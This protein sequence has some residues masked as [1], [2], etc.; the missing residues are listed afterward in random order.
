VP[1]AIDDKYAS[2]NGA[3]GFLGEPVTGELTA[4]DRIG[5]YRHYQ[6]GSIYWSP[7]TGA[8]ETHGLIRADWQST[9]WEQGPLGY[10]T[11]DESPTPDGAGRFN[12]FQWGVCYW[13][14]ATGAHEVHGAIGAKYF[15]LG[16]PGSYL[17]YPL[18]DE[19]GAPDR[20]GRFNHF[21]GGS[22]YW[23]ADLGAHEVHGAIR[24]RWADLGW[25]RGML[26]YPTSDEHDTPDSAGRIGDFQG[27]S[28]LW[29]K[30]VGATERVTAVGYRIVLERFHID[31]TRAPDEDTDVVAYT[32]EA[33][34][35]PD[36]RGTG[37]RQEKY[38]DVDNG[39]HQLGWSFDALVLPS[40]DDEVRISYSIVNAG[41]A[42]SDAAKLGRLL[43]GLGNLCAALCAGVFGFTGV[44]ATVATK[45]AQYVGK[46]LDIDCDGGVAA[47]A[48]ALT[49]GDLHDLTAATGTHQETRFY[50]GT[51]SNW[52]CGSNSK[53]T[54]TWSVTYE[55]PLS[56]V[57]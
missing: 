18:T 53:Y 54:V 31:N 16:G 39:D 8:H 29:S 43:E 5:K 27:G 40:A 6:G 32:V 2:L 33:P 45:F 38:G 46:A 22:I 12:T 52:G 1:S 42:S 34:G 48:I 20:V 10:P 17:G 50:P 23:K 9:G 19:T 30:A 24:G 36:W 57:G 35:H 47:D 25:E 26:G 3:S 15:A 41:N 44:W 4:P 56:P 49:I 51:D 7:T 37:A 14:P 55:P 21:Q 13:T 11:S 28:I